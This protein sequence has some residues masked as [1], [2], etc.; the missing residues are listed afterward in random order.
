MG[1]AEAGWVVS[2]V[3]SNATVLS[4]VGKDKGR[5]VLGYIGM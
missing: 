1:G 5:A 3:L 2:V 4:D